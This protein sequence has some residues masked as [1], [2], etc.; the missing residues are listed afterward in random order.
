MIHVIHQLQRRWKGGSRIVLPL[1]ML[2]LAGLV[3]GLG[4]LFGG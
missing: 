3:A 1:A 2:A 4:L